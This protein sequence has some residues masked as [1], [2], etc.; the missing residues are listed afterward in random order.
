MHKSVKNIF[1]GF[2]K[3]I[4]GYTSWMYADI[5]G[6]VT[7]GLGNKIDPI[8]LAL[9]LPWRWKVNNK[10]A[11]KAEIRAEWVAVKTIYSSNKGIAPKFKTSYKDNARLFLT[12]PDISVLVDRVLLEFETTLKSYYPQWESWPADAQL[13]ALSLAWSVGP[14]FPKTWKNTHAALLK[15]DFATVAKEA[16]ISEVGNAGVKPRNVANQ[17]LFENAAKVIKIEADPTRVW[18]WGEPIGKPRITASQVK[19]GK[20]NGEIKKLQNKLE[21]SGYD[22]YVDGNYGNQTRSAVRKY[23]TKFKLFVDGVAGERTLAHMGFKTV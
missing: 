9:G 10:R 2:N 22:L 4:E 17:R 3:P 16:V 11:T 21:D 7:T 14:H 1:V 8:E 5:K 13:G 6:Y 20:T 23:Q 19:F 12:E 18:L 15:Q